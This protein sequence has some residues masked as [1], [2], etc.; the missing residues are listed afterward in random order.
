MN[1][2]K[3]IMEEICKEL[4]INLNIIS[5]GWVYVLEKNGK[6]R[7]LTATTFDLNNHAIGKIFDDKYA[8]YELLKNIDVPVINHSLAYNDDNTSDYA[9]GKNTKDYIYDFYNKNDCNIVLKA[10]NGYGGRRVFHV[11]EKSEIDQ[12]LE[13]LFLN[14]NSI[15]MCPY[16]NIKN[17]YRIIVLNGNIELMYKKIKPAIIG[18]G[19]STIRDLLVKENE[20]F[21]KD[22]Y[23]SSE[24]DRVLSLGEKYEF[25][26]QFNLSKGASISL[27][28]DSEVKEDILKIINKITSSIEVGFASIDIVELYNGEKMVMEIN[29]G[30][31]MQHFRKLAD[32][33]YEISKKI[34]KKAVMKLFD[35]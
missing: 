10:N 19:K 12:V 9:F 4:L 5:N 32:N 35:L 33:G 2:F 34:Y 29:S 18:D 17:E 31:A 27:D 30:V 22:N 6:R 28:I 26:W 16:Y 15:S 20:H 7:F 23:L 13:K 11:T 21:F 24:Y 8:T 14:C 3:S 25:N 1:E